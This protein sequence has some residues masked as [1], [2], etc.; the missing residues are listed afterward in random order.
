MVRRA[1]PNADW[2]RR[3]CRL[4]LVVALGAM[5]AGCDK[6][7]DWWFSPWRGDGQACREQAPKPPQ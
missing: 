6:C 5:L 2:R 3:A 4:A 1:I 7:G